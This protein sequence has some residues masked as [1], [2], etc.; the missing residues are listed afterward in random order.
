MNRARTLGA[1]LVSARRAL[2]DASTRGFPRRLRIFDSP[3]DALRIRALSPKHKFCI[4]VRERVLAR[5][6][7]HRRSRLL[8]GAPLESLA[9]ASRRLHPRRQPTVPPRQRHLPHH[10]LPTSHPHA[11]RQLQQRVLQSR[12]FARQRRRQPLQL[13]HPRPRLSFQFPL[14]LPRRRRRLPIR[15][16]PLR[17]PMIRRVPRRRR[18]RHHDARRED[19]DE[20]EKTTDETDHSHARSVV[21][22]VSH[23]A[24]RRAAPRHAFRAF[25]A[26][27]SRLS[28]TTPPRLPPRAS[29]SVVV[30][31]TRAHS[32]A[33]RPG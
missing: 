10:H 1:W 16:Q 28:F 25:R 32:S 29:S 8:A 20:R 17:P 6:R 33:P 30:V 27:L 23:A 4:V 12:V 13:R 24:P 15:R 3:R 9:V 14:P 5:R 2:S 22:L 7:R 31:G 11:A 26:R 19:D 21:P 18:R